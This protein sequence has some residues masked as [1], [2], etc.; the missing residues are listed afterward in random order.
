MCQEIQYGTY[1]WNVWSSKNQMSEGS[2]KRVTKSCHRIIK[3]VFLAHLIKSVV[4]AACSGA[5]TVF[6]FLGHA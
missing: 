1:D 5:A 2:S 6:T 3:K 4:I